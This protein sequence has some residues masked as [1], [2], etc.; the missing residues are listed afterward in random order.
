MTEQV[1]NLISKVAVLIMLI[2]LFLMLRETQQE[3][4]T[5]KSETDS[6]IARLTKQC[7]KVVKHE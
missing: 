1:S 3:L 4:K 5:L 6:N 2:M 7:N